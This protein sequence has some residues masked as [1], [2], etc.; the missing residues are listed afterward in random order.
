MK[1]LILAGGGHGHVSVL[2]KLR[3]FLIKDWEIVL[4]SDKKHQYYSGM[5][6]DYIAGDY[7]FEDVT[8]DLDDLCKK[9]K[10][11][12]FREKILE[13]NPV[14]KKV[15][16]ENRT[17]NYNLLSMDLGSRTYPLHPSSYTVKP[18][19][20]LMQ[21]REDIARKKSGRFVIIGSGASA[22]EL[23]FGDRQYIKKTNGLLS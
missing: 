9:A 1:R 3:T 18:L 15:S 23:A 4:I 16:T 14:Q 11:L 5:I 13:I 7:T 2:K 19:D 12:F 21:I 20:Q 22:I 8:F 17:L 10:I 6:S